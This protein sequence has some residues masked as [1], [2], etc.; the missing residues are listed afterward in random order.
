MIKALFLDDEPLALRQM[1]LYAEKTPGVEVVG[2]CLSADEAMARIGEADVLFT[3][4]DMPDMSGLDFVRSMENPPLVVFTTAYAEFA[5]EGFRVNAVDYLLKP[6]SLKEFQRSVERAESTLDLLSRKKAQDGVLHLRTGRKTVSVPLGKILFIESMSEYVKFH[7]DGSD[8]PLIVLYSMKKLEEELP[9]G[10]FTRIHRSYIVSLP[11]ILEAS[12]GSVTMDGG[13][14]LP[15]SDT[16][17]T[18][19]RS[20]LSGK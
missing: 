9:R 6:F 4:I 18:A 16:Y 19:I 20:Y 5:V 11:H 13:T 7:L 3:D 1:T 15:V 8:S 17:K 14:V 10:I 12:A 2:A